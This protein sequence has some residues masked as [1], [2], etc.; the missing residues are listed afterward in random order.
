MF[1]MLDFKEKGY[2]GESRFYI[3]RFLIRF[4]PQVF[5]ILEVLAY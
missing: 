3:R 2:S 1:P 5:D 4:S